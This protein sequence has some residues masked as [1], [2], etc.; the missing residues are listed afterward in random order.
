MHWPKGQKVKGQG[1]TVTKT[2]TLARLLVTRAATAVCCCCWV[3]MSIRLPMFSCFIV[4]QRSPIG[5][6]GKATMAWIRVLGEKSSEVEAYNAVVKYTLNFNVCWQKSK[7]FSNL[8][9]FCCR[10]STFRLRSLSIELHILVV[11]VTLE[12]RRSWNRATC[13]RRSACGDTPVPL[14]CI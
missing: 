8:L 3:C 7:R 5:Y 4:S 1:H 2:V 6:N 14:K 11:N 13:G 9:N 10:F 12:M